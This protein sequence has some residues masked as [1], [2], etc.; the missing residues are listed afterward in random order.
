MGRRSVSLG[1]PSVD[2]LTLGRGCSM[3]SWPSS[4]LDQLQLDEVK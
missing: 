3:R 4:S 1:V 2:Q